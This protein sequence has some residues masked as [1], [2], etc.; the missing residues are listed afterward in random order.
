[1]RGLTISTLAFVLAV[2]AVFLVNVAGTALTGAVAPE[3]LSTDRVPVTGTAQTMI[4][5]VNFAAGA[6]GAAVFVVLAPNKPTV[7]ALVFLGVVVLLDVAAAVAW[8]DLVPAWFTIGVVVLAPLQVW[9][10]ALVGLS[11]RRRWRGTVEPE[12]A[13]RSE[14]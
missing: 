13:D 3:G 12:A 2:V 7:H 4:L 8:W 5:A 10:G 14:A 11:F 6:A 1:M 9:A